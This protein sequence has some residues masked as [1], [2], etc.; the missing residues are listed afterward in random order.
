MALCV[1]LLLSCQR[2]GLDRSLDLRA[3]AVLLSQSETVFYAKGDVLSNPRGLGLSDQETRELSAP[4]G[5]LTRSLEQLGGHAAFGILRSARAVL[6]GASDFRPPTGIGRVQSRRC[7]IVIS[8]PGKPIDLKGYFHQKPITTVQGAPVWSWSASLS[9]F[10]EGDPRPS[11]VY[12]SEI[13][14]SLL[15][16]SND[17]DR[18]RSMATS[19]QATS[20]NRADSTLSEISDWARFSS[21]E[22]WGY[23]SYRQSEVVSPDAAGLRNI[24]PGAKSLIFFVDPK[25]KSSVLRLSVA[26]ADNSADKLNAWGGLPQ[27]K[28]SGASVWETTIPLAG[29][30]KSAEQIFDVMGLFGFA[31]YL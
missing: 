29:S 28:P 18:L 10:G 27:L 16:I 15:V 14:K 24:G 20:P 26:G 7:Y 13:G 30:E 25:N 17:L 1:S 21:H 6:V 5:Y 9:E 22:L 12:A 4:F 2:R 11:T 23:R 31:V 19:I 3:T 8:E